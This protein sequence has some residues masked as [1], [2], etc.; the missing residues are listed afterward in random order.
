[1][2]GQ[3]SQNLHSGH[4]TPNPILFALIHVGH[5][6]VLFKSQNDEMTGSSVL[7]FPISWHLHPPW[8]VGVYA[9]FQV[10]AERD[11]DLTLLLHNPTLTGGVR[12]S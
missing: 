5:I 2:S 1:M 10:S 3:P 11:Y 12:F 4:L 8:P 6:A 9:V 7:F